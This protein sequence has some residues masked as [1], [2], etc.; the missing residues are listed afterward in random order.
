MVAS[1]VFEGMSSEMRTIKTLANPLT[2]DEKYLPF[3]AFS[4]KVDFWDDGLSTQNKR[5]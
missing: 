5:N 4:L 3:L 2:C 1:K